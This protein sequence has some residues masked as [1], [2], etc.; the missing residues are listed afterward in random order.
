MHQLTVTL[1]LP[2]AVSGH[3]QHDAPGVD[4]IAVRIT[5]VNHEFCFDQLRRTD[6]IQF[7][8]CSVCTNEVPLSRCHVPGCHGCINLHKH[9]LKQ[10]PGTPAAVAQYRRLQCMRAVDPHLQL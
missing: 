9:V 4:M 1:D 7:L 8:G 10:K 6:A 2:P 5:V 3:I